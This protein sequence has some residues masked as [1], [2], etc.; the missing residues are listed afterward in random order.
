MSH[1]YILTIIYSSWNLYFFISFLKMNTLGLTL[2]TRSLNWCSLNYNL[3][4]TSAFWTNHLHCH[5]TLSI[6]HKS[7]T[8][9]WSTLTRSSP[10]FA[11]ISL[12][13]WAQALIIII[14]YSFK[15]NCF[16]WS[17]YSFHKF[18]IQLYL[19]NLNFLRSWLTSWFTKKIIKICKKFFF[20]IFCSLSIFEKIAKT[21]ERIKSTLSPL[22]NL[23]L[24]NL[25]NHLL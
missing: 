11:F 10:W 16:F 3:T 22:N 8:C 12:A 18:N 17:I 21:T 1:S 19:Y 20:H 14:T 25:A 9:A 13:H 24:K 2:R 4:L 6:I 23:Y 15:L 7:F 5:R